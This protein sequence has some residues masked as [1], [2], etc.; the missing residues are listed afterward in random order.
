MKPGNVQIFQKHLLPPANVRSQRLHYL[1]KPHFAL[2]EVKLIFGK[3][4]EI[5]VWGWIFK[6]E[7]NQ[8]IRNHLGTKGARCSEGP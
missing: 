3:N 8:S 6:K 1:G 5:R 2:E 7:E 4:L